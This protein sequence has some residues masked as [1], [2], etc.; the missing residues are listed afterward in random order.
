MINRRLRLDT[1]TQSAL[2]ESMRYVEDQLEHSRT[3]LRGLT[4]DLDSLRRYHRQ[5]LL[6][7]PLGVCTIDHQRTITLWNLAMQGMTG[8]TPNETI[9]VSLQRLPTPWGSLIAGFASARNDHVHHL[10]VEH[11]G[12]SRWFN[13]H[14]AE[15]PTPIFNARLEEETGTSLVMIFEDLTDLEN[16]EAELVHSERL[17]SIGRLAAGVAHEI[18]NPV[19]GI[20]SL[21]QNLREEHDREI[22]D[23]SI[24]EILN[25]TRRITAIVKT[26]M[27]FS[28]SGGIGT[29][30]RIFPLKEIAD[31]AIRLVRL[32]HHGRQ[33]SC[34]NFCPKDLLIEADR[35]ALSQVLVNLL[36]NACDASEPG[37]RVELLA[38]ETGEW[39]K[40]E[41]LDQG[42][43]IEPDKKAYI[44]EPFFTTKSPGEG[45]GLGLALVYKIVREHRGRIGL[46]SE[47]GIG[48]RVILELP[49]TARLHHE[50]DP[51]H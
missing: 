50:T 21:A 15:I 24:E 38:R 13:L 5:V 28:R 34:E 45:T 27:N 35:Q 49:K 36:S 47:P 4:A 2:A 30:I 32:T 46:D 29:D 23:E 19:T 43:G 40:I 16:L 48:T 17:A 25:Q 51:D 33:I 41:I 6:D 20:A 22:I 8:L 14:K 10:E 42:K 11:R 18:G 26:L 7:L 37:D 44:F 39:I 1:H 9:G 12:Q 3:H 31:E